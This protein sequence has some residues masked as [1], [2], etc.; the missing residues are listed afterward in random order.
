MLDTLSI[1][2]TLTKLPITMSLPFLPESL[3]SRHDGSAPWC[4]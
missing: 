4:G 2:L 1:F 3:D